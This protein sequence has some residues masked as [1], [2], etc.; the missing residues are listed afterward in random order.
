[1]PVHGVEVIRD[2]GQRRGELVVGSTGVELQRDVVVRNEIMVLP[3]CFEQQLPFTVKQADVRPVELVKA[4]QIEI[5]VQRLDVEFS[6]R[7][8]GHRVDAD[9]GA[10]VMRPA[11]NLRHVVDAAGD[12]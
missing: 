2:S 11:R 5:H 4:H 10:G 6:V 9:Q 1:M 12:V 7:G 3:L 8:V